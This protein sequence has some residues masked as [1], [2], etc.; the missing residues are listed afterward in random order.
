[1]STIEP[2]FLLIVTTKDGLTIRNTPRPQSEGGV[3]LRVEAPGAQLYAQSIHNVGGAEY[4]LLVPRNPNQPEWV[5]VSEASGAIRYAD[6][7]RL[8]SSGGDS[9]TAALNRIADALFALAKK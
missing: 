2:K 1:M 4:A 5:R 7:I 3:R 6:V 8:E 9:Q